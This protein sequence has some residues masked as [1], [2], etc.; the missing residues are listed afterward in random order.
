[1][2]MFVRM[3]LAAAADAHLLHHG[4]GGIQRISVSS[5]DRL[6]SPRSLDERARSKGLISAD[7]ESSICLVR[8]WP[9]LVIGF[10]F[11]TELSRKEYPDPASQLLFC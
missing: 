3:V 2:E 7:T 10:F 1:M 6:P 4:G 5:S 11:L 9:R 8:K